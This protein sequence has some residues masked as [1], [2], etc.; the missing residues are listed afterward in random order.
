MNHLICKTCRRIIRDANFECYCEIN[1]GMEDKYILCKSC[2]DDAI[3][4]GKIVQC[5]ACGNYF[6]NDKLCN[7][8]VTAYHT[9][10]TC[11]YCKGDI[12]SGCSEDELTEKLTALGTL[13]LEKFA[14][15]ATL[16][17]GTNR[18]YMISAV[19][20]NDM[21]LKFMKMADIKYITSISYSMILCEEDVVFS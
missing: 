3:E 16:Q 4:K 12:F 18:G 2:C 9:F 17:N 7:K 10:C 20:A 15:I 14:V 8:K 11:P 21:M 13:R 6:T 19:D 1:P 5:E